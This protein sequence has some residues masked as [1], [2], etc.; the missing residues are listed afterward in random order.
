MQYMGATLIHRS[1]QL[2]PDGVTIEMVIWVVEP[3][4][5]GSAHGYKYR[6][7]AGR[8]GRTLV[9]YDNEAGKGNHKHLGAEEAEVPFAFVS[10][11]QTVRAFLAD[12][13]R[14]TEG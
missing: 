7:Y 8:G 2:R 5:A 9:R 13:A 4:V 11:E 10:M 3:A 12:V 14:M 6:L 1:K